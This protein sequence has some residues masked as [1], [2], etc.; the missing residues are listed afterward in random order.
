MHSV[1]IITADALQIPGLADWPRASLR[2]RSTPEEIHSGTRV[3]W[4]PRYSE[5][6]CITMYSPCTW[7]C[8]G[9]A[10]STLAEHTDPLCYSCL[11]LPTSAHQPTKSNSNSVGQRT[12]TPRCLLVDQ[13]IAGARDLVACG[14]R[15]GRPPC[16]SSRSVEVHAVLAQTLWEA[17]V[18]RPAT[19]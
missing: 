19:W 7:V 3:L 17:V 5:E 8:F 9:F 13:H 2:P 18:T 10:D 1:I 16:A 15:L 4:Y 11:D 12:A 14:S 6:L